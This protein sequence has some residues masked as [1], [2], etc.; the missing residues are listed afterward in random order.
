MLCRLCERGSLA[1][2]LRKR[3]KMDEKL[4]ASYIVQVL[5]GLHYLHAQGVI[6]RD[7]KVGVAFIMS[8]NIQRLCRAFGAQGGN[9]L[10]TAKGVV[11]VQLVPSPLSFSAV[12]VAAQLTDFGVATKTDGK[13]KSD[14]V[15]GTPY[16]SEC[17]SA[18]PNVSLIEWLQFAVAP[19]IIGMTGQQSSACDIWYAR[20]EPL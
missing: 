17:M 20:V 16:W 6:H 18:R 9:I 14:S 11:K 13:R 19:E 10:E 15:V 12:A 5:K 3:G 4:V 8:S 2:I 7:I 1:S